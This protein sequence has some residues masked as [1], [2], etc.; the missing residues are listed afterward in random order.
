[1]YSKIGFTT[2]SSS[3]STTLISNTTVAGFQIVRLNYCTVPSVSNISA[4]NL[5]CYGP[6][7]FSSLTSPSNFTLYGCPLTCFSPT[8]MNSEQ[9]SSSPPVFVSL[10]TNA[11][12]VTYYNVTSTLF[13]NYIVQ[14]PVPGNE[15]I[16]WMSTAATTVTPMSVVSTLSNNFIWQSTVQTSILTTS[17][18]TSISQSSI[19]TKTSVRDQDTTS[20]TQMTWFS[21][22]ASLTNSM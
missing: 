1:M 14:C 13:P 22:T 11:S 12:N 7:N 9:V 18:P 4:F 6:A 5:T 19:V 10:M 20:S 3:V 16:N 8:T 21:S 2:Y 17:I 15:P